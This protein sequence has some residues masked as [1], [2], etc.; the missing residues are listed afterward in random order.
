MQRTLQRSNHAAHVDAWMSG[1]PTHPPEQTIGALEQGL[2]AL[3]RRSHVTLGTATLEA[4]V[5]RVLHDAAL[6]FPALAVV[7]LNG[8]SGIDVE[9]LRA[10]VRTEDAQ[11]IHE[12]TRFIL[13]EFL[14]VVGR[15]T[16]EALTPALHAAFPRTGPTLDSAR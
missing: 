3:W 16:A 5:L 1:V 6:R 2:N 14:D 9:E 15:L 11:Q 8:G 7:H 13:Y 4:V 10:R 12:G